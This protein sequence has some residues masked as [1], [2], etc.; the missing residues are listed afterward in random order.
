[1]HGSALSATVVSIL[2]RYREALAHTAHVRPPQTPP[3]QLGS[4]TD[5][6]PDADAPCHLA[7]PSR[8]EL[9]TDLTFAQPGGRTNS[10]D[11]KAELLGYA[12]RVE[13][14]RSPRDVLNELHTVTT[15]HLPLAVMG[16]ARLRLKSEGSP[17]APLGESRSFM[18]AFLRAG[19][20]NTA[21]SLTADFV[22][23]CSWRQPAWQ[24]IRGR[25]S[26]G[27]FNQ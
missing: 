15:R 22:R 17:P 20:R 8:E 23:S 9:M 25:K 19:G 13:E 6:F 10:M 16:A 4:S 3:T 5:G 26:G 11:L 12:D 18:R 7:T 1:M 14:L 27:C 24:R 2:G 21:L